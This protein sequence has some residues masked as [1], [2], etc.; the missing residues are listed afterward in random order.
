VFNAILLADDTIK[1]A[2]WT[3]GVDKRG[4]QFPDSIMLHNAPALQGLKEIIQLD[5]AAKQRHRP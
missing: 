2:F 5:G 4:L 3:T 1:S